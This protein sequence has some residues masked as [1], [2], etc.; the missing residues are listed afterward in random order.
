MAVDTTDQPR[1]SSTALVSGI[2]D[3]LQR[4]LRQEAQLARQELKQ[5]WQKTKSAAFSFAA[6]SVAL[7]FSVL[8]LLFML[9][10]L[11]AYYTSIPTWGCYGIVGGILALAAIAMLM[12]GSQ[13]ASQ[14]QLPPPQTA[15]SLKENAQWIQNQV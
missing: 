6:G 4:L 2:V 7:V 11:L 10:Y 3:D 15:A 5:E 8:I 13:R 9:V 12:M 1:Q 14:I